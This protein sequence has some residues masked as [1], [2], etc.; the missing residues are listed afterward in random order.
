MQAAWIVFHG[1]EKA[2]NML[3]EEIARHSVMPVHDQY[4]FETKIIELCSIG[5][6]HAGTRYA[7][8]DK[9]HQPPPTLAHT[10]SPKDKEYA[11]GKLDEGFR[12]EHCR[13]SIT[14]L[15]EM[16]EQGGT[17][18]MFKTFAETKE[19]NIYAINTKKREIQMRRSTGKLTWWLGVDTL[20][21]VHDRIHAGQLDLDPHEIDRIKPTWGSYIA[22]LLKHFGCR[23]AAQ[24][25]AETESALEP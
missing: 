21:D 2:K 5:R 4:P 11:I 12:C 7:I 17:K 1:Q 16:A 24:P 20:I 13:F 22:A 10:G 23:R 15:K 14:R 3:T 8:V 9:G 18:E 25:R 19:M 6:K